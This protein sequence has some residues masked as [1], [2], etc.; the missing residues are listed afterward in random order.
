MCQTVIDIEET[1]PINRNL[2][3]FFFTRKKCKGG[4]KL[5]AGYQCQADRKKLKVITV[6]NSHKR[7]LDQITT[8]SAVSCKEVCVCHIGC[9]NPQR[10]VCEQGCRYISF[11][12]PPEILKKETEFTELI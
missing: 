3:P 1:D 2:A 9:N 12:I 6:F 11:V 10:G 4:I 7:V 8:E 5:Q